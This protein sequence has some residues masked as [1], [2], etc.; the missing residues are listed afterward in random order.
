MKAHRE[1]FK[2]LRKMGGFTMVEVMFA[3]GIGSIAIVGMLMTVISVLQTVNR[4]QHYAWAQSEVNQSIQ[5]IVTFARNAEAIAAID[6]SGYWVDLRL[7]DGTTNRFEYIPS[8]GH[9]SGGGA[10][11]MTRQRPGEVGATHLVAEGVTKVMTLPVRNVFHQTGPN[12]MRVAYRVTKPGSP[13]NCP[14]EVDVGVY[15]RN[16]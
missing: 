4:A 15:L 14:A 13:R 3:T 12:T 11:R 9:N 7:P 16:N 8:S 1:H 10:L 5:K 2:R 6:E